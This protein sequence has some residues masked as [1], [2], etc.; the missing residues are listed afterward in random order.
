MRL[1]LHR[2]QRSSGLLGNKVTFKLE[3]RVDISAEEQAFIRK[4]NVGREIIYIKERVALA[5]EA[6]HATWKGIA[7]NLAAYA[8][9]LTIRIDDL[10]KGTVV[11]CKDFLEM[12]AVEEQIVTA[13]QNFKAVLQSAAH[14]DGE[15]VIEL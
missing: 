14:F 4:Y 11:E 15:E 13:C 5:D 1:R 8:T 7:R 6:D 2:S 10:L 3:A 12:L 9:T